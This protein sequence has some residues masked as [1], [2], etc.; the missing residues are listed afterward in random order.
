M[1]NFLH[2]DDHYLTGKQ[3]NAADENFMKPDLL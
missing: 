2:P 3:R 1:L